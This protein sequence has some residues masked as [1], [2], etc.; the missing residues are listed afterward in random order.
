[1]K[2]YHIVAMAPGGVIGKENR[3][4]W[5]SSADLKHFKKLTLGSTVIMGR[6]TFESLG[7][8][9]PGRD[10]FIL[11]HSEKKETAGAEFFHSLE[12][13]LK[14]VKTEKAFIMGGGELYRETLD[15]VNGIYLTQVA[16]KY[17]GDTFY[18]TKSVEEL[19]KLG[20]E[21]VFREKSSED[22]QL[23]FIELRKRR[24]D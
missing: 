20:F 17:E 8:P 24:N 11:S 4:P 7:K 10:N 5:H 3:L 12:E 14:A 18:P 9:L 13:A 21:I 19:E 1:M 2:L 22:P 23:E 6:K 16:G 15:R